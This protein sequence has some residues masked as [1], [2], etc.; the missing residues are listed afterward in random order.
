MEPWGSE[1]LSVAVDAS[2]GLLRHAGLDF[3]FGPPLRGRSP[4]INKISFGRLSLKSPGSLFTNPAGELLCLHEVECGK[5]YNNYT[6]DKIPKMGVW[7]LWKTILT[8]LRREHIF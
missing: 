2:A 5:G 8:G 6:I 7:S 3:G 1:V 4:D